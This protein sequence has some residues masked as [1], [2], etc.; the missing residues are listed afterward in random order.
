MRAFLIFVLV[1]GNLVFSVLA[2]IG[3]KISAFGSWRNFLTWQIMGNLS[4]LA[5]VL[6]FT[7]L[8]RLWPLHVAYPITTGLGVIGVEVFAAKLLFKEQIGMFQWLGG[9]LIAVGIILIGVER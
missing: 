8:L 3:F 5:G 9:L 1:V 4:G 2:N 7:G 6:T